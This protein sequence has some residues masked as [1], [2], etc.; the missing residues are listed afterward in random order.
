MSKHVVLATTLVN[1]PEKVRGCM[2]LFDGSV[3]LKDR[4]RSLQL[5]IVNNTPF[6]FKL[7]EA[8]HFDSGTSITDPAI[9]LLPASVSAVCQ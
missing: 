8:T 9:K 3:N 2:I 1:I 7:A 6:S 4:H 5:S